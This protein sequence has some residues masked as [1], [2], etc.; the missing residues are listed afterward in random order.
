[1]RRMWREKIQCK[2]K[3]N[4]NEEKMQIGKEQKGSHQTLTSELNNIK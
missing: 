1:M 3:N 2:I 4:K